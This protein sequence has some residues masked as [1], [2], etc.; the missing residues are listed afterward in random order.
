[1]DIHTTEKIHRNGKKRKK[2]ATEEGVRGKGHFRH[3]TIRDDLEARESAPTP[4]E[5]DREIKLMQRIQSREGLK[6]IKW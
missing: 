3:Y 2:I 5:L 4:R 6:D 1:M